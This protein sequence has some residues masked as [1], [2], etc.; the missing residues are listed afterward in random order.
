MSSIGSMI[1]ELPSAHEVYKH[2]L[3]PEQP[4]EPEHDE[5]LWLQE[6]DVFGHG[7]QLDDGPEAHAQQGIHDLGES[8]WQSVQSVPQST[9][10]RKSMNGS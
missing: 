9:D 2:H 6:E 4:E 7:F 1:A 3:E 8:E 10:D 5:Q